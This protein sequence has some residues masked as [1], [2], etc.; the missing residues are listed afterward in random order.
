MSNER[1]NLG[2]YESIG[3][4]IELIDER[5]T[6]AGERIGLKPY[7]TDYELVTDE[8]MVEL[9]PYV[10]MPIHYRHWRYGKQALQEKKR[11]GTFH[12]F[13]A[14]LNTS[15]SICYL[16]T[17]NTLEM[18]ALVMGH[19]KWG[20][21]DFFANNKLFKETAASSVVSRFALA[22]EKIDGLIADPNWG[23]DSVEAILDAAHALED[24]VAWL[25]SVRQ[26]SDKE[27][28]DAAM[29][30]LRELRARIADAGSRS[31]LD[32][33]MLEKEAAELQA[34]LMRFPF[35]PTQDIL[36]FL[37]DPANTPKLPEEAHMLISI[38]RD[39]GLY[40]QPQGRTK[41]MNEG[42]ASYWEKH[43]L[44]QP[45]LTFP[46]EMRMSLA[47][48]WT[49]HSRQATNSYFD[50][51]ALGLH[52]F[53]HIDE[54]YGYDEG[55]AEMEVKPLVYVDENTVTEA[56]TPIT[57]K[58]TK[59]NRDKMLEVR[60]HYDDNRFLEEFLQ[61]EL[62]EKINLKS[63]EWIRRLMT[64]INGLLRKNGWNPQL[65]R[66]PL[67]LTL[68]GLMEVVELWGNTAETSQQLHAQAGAPIF[69]VPTQ[70]LQEM[71]TVL[72]IVGAF[73]ANPHKARRQ[74]VLRT[75]YHSKPMIWL[76]DTGRRSDG[77]WTLK[78]E[79]DENFGPLMQSEARDT[80][81]YFR[82]LCCEPCR[83]VTMEQRTDRMGRPS[84][85]PVPY[86]YFTE[87]GITVKERFL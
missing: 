17:T 80:L 18:Q 32:K 61:E 64:Q 19:A 82:R 41:F 5:M 54:K 30:K 77:V 29:E 57:V 78:H 42:W 62:F 70:I 11:A 37:A 15:P 25:P 2:V 76:M 13:E 75:A 51:Y 59:R 14:V 16:G 66:D 38:V 46:I 9:I 74:L 53:E 68:E 52:V 72:Q 69:P 63:L 12:I 56:E 7:P 50:P 24:H 4:S 71:G 45:E 22:K 65:I 79:F 48:Y 83:L 33:E 34:R 6:R 87:D 67:P 43:L 28:R 39:Q 55:E 60:K 3:K 31:N 35:F 36:G 47:K 27:V 23:W 26:E 58:Y 1:T 81:K 10:M 73:D 44:L 49:M 21:V 84:G 85:P 8:Q 40:F 86:E 20:H